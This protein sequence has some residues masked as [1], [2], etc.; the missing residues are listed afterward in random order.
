MKTYRIE[1]KKYNCPCSWI[2]WLPPQ[3]I[4]TILLRYTEEMEVPLPKSQERR[5]T[6]KHSSYL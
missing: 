4:P 5:S 3:K 2:A 1:M 6:Q